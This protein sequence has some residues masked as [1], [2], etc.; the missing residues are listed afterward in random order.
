MTDSESSEDD[1]VIAA[2]VSVINIVYEVIIEITCMVK[3]R[4]TVITRVFIT[5]IKSKKK[6]RTDQTQGQC[7]SRVPLHRT[8]QGTG[9]YPKSPRALQ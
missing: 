8:A 5:M 2:K 7:H 1:I 9:N 3:M 6:T 4:I